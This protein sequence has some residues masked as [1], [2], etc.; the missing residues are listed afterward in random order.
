MM[1][2][3]GHP[4]DSADLDDVNLVLVGLDQERRSQ[5]GIRVANRVQ[6]PLVECSDVTKHHRTDNEG[7]DDRQLTSRSDTAS[8][9]PHIA[10]RRTGLVVIA[11]RELAV[12]AHLNLAGSMRVVLHDDV[13]PQH[14]RNTKSVATVRLDTDGLATDDIVDLIVEAWYAY[15]T[16]A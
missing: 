16:S 1:N 8:P 12:D 4:S 2:R 3:R 11:A 14:S 7:R 5:I 15:A 13:C 6:R 10:R 9:G